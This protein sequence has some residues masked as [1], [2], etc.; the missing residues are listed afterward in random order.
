MY[1]VYILLCTDGSLYTG[2][3]KDVAKRFLQ[4][5]QGTGARYTKAHRPVRIVYVERK[6]T[7]ATALKREYA[8]KQLTR[9][10]KLQ[11]IG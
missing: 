5:Q 10:Q 3:A 7:R 11:L 4:H 1:T 2:V 6:R 9:D 8:I